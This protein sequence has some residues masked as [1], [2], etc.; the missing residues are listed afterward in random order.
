MWVLSAFIKNKMTRKLKWSHFQLWFFVMFGSS[1]PSGVLFQFPIS[2]YHCSIN[3]NRNWMLSKPCFWPSPPLTRA[4][5]VSSEIVAAFNGLVGLACFDINSKTKCSCG[6]AS[7][8][9]GLIALKS[10]NH[11]R[12]NLVVHEN[13]FAAELFSPSSLHNSFE[14]S[15]A[16]YVNSESR[17][18]R[19]KFLISSKTD[20]IFP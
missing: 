16:S 19:K 11:S 1:S 5:K 17:W 15:K 3:R 13:Q 20:H 18:I 7:Q 10:M 4:H 6:Y 2:T 8:K 9:V 14:Y 12:E